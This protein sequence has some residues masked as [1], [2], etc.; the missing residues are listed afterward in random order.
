MNFKYNI[1]RFKLIYQ[2]DISQEISLDLN[3]IRNYYNKSVL[4]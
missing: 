3:N 2:K 1:F 4:N